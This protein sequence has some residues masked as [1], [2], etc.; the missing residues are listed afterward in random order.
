[1]NSRRSTTQYLV[2]VICLNA[3]IW[4]PDSPIWDA[5]VAVISALNVFLLAYFYTK[6]PQLTAD[7]R[8]EISRNKTAE[9]EAEL[10]MDPLNLHELDDILMNEHKS[11]KK[12]G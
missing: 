12:D 5:V 1:M 10:G 9:L 7:Q 6:G 8:L 3:I 11:Q 4:G 2:C